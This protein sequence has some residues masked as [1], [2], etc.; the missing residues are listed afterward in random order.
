MM[1]VFS[2]LPVP[3][4][5]WWQRFEWDCRAHQ[6]SLFFGSLFVRLIHN[7]FPLC[8][9]NIWIVYLYVFSFLCSHL[10]VLLRF[11]AH[12]FVVSVAFIGSL[13]AIVSFSL[14]VSCEWESRRTKTR[15]KK[16][17]IQDRKNT[18]T[19]KHTQQYN[20]KGAVRIRVALGFDN[21][22][23]HDLATR[24]IFRH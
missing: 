1:V 6:P 7:S 5:G 8:L 19:H 23:F 3:M 4:G 21:D 15:I 20:S 12:S 22:I 18:Q 13:L 14:E 16:R 17:E 24:Y 10:F 2:L 11:F 9:I